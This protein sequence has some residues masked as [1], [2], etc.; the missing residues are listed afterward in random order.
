MANNPQT[1]TLPLLITKGLILFPKVQRLIDAGRDFSINSIKVSK[2]KA[3][4]LI[5]ITSQ[6]ESD[7]ENPNIDEIYKTGVLARVMSISERDKRIRTRV[8][9][10]ERVSLTDIKFDDE[11]KCYNED[12]TLRDFYEK[13]QK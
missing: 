9:V 13:Y 7:A 10:I 2:D 1:L 12:K 4:S 3:D 5:L 6:I 8:E 11:D